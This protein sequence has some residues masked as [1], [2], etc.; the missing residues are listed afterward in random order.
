MFAQMLQEERIICPSSYLPSS[1]TVKATKK[2]SWHEEA[3][4]K[5]QKYL[6]EKLTQ[7]IV[8]FQNMSLKTL[9][10]IHIYS[11]SHRDG[12]YD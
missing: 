3:S 4:L 12:K 2:T 7:C 6:P 11:R 9:R 1:H 5:T 10:L 8:K